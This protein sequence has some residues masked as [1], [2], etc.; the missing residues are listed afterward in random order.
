MDG[1]R[2]T[3]REEAD[4]LEGFTRFEVGWQGVVSRQI[5]STRWLLSAMDGILQ[6]FT[7][8]LTRTSRRLKTIPSNVLLDGTVEQNVPYLKQFI[9][10]LFSSS[11]WRHSEA[12]KLGIDGF[13]RLFESNRDEFITTMSTQC[14]SA[15]TMW[16]LLNSCRYSHAHIRIWLE[17]KVKRSINQV[18]TKASSLPHRPIRSRSPHTSLHYGSNKEIISLLLFLPLSLFYHYMN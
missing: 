7:Y 13:I 18:K 2:K 1:W 3:F 15:R 6:L 14:K 8:E 9:I 12:V 5:F 10:W 4:Q 16:I 17:F 11:D